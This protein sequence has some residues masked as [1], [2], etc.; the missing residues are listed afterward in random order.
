LF[1]PQSHVPTMSFPYIQQV[2]NHCFKVYASHL[3]YI[4]QIQCNHNSGAMEL[5]KPIE[6]NENNRW[7]VMH[8]KQSIFYTLRTIDCDIY[9]VEI[10][11]RYEQRAD[12]KIVLIFNIKFTLPV[13]SVNSK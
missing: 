1:F 11:I 12:I 9:R 8:Q 7:Y 6:I 10:N 3:M 4:D 2:E 13:Y 5:L